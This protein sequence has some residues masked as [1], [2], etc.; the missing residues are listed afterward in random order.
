[1]HTLRKSLILVLALFGV[2][3]TSACDNTFRG[4]RQDIQDTGAAISGS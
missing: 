4:A 1:M 3:A 2:L